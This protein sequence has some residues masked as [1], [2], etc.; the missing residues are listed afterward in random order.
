M[1]VKYCFCLY[2]LWIE[3]YRNK[4]IYLKIHTLFLSFFIYFLKNLNKVE[5]IFAV[6]A[7]VEY[8]I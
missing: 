2:W 7:P 4:W 5:L 3:T 8:Q 6:Q 1:V